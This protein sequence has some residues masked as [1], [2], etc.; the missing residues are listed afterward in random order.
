[1]K[2]IQKDRTLVR[3]STPDPI[4]NAIVVS[5]ALPDH[6][7][8]PIGEIYPDFGN[9]EN[10]AMYASANTHGEELFPSTSGLL[11]F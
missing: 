7:T 5:R 9:G 6:S 8:E 11:I 1:M 3:F 4:T 2:N 10:S